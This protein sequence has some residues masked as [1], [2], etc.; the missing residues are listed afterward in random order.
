MPL[1]S[2]TSM[3]TMFDSG[4]AA[5]ASRPAR[6]PRWLRRRCRGRGRHRGSSARSR[7]GSP[8]RP[9]GLRSRAA[10]GLDPGVDDRDRRGIRGRSCVPDARAGRRRTAS[11]GC[12]V[13]ADRT[14]GASL[15]IALNVGSLGQPQDLPAGELRGDAADGAEAV[16]HA[17]APTGIGAARSPHVASPPRPGSRRAMPWTMTSNVRF[18][19]AC[20]FSSRPGERYARMFHVVRLRGSLRRRPQWARPGRRRRAASARRR[21]RPC[22]RERSSESPPWRAC[23][24]ERS[25]G[26]L[27]STSLLSRIVLSIPFSAHGAGP[28]INS[29]TR[30]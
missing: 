1:S 20:A 28:Q 14:T 7:P 15:V 29:H 26:F 4:R 12:S 27:P 19:L 8:R 10:A 21:D 13:Y 2:I 30:R 6:R 18:G 16:A 5:R 24:R 22:P 17:D 3:E 11:A 23:P 9:R 25:I